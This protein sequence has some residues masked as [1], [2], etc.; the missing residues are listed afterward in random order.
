MFRQIGYVLCGGS[1]ATGYLGGSAAPLYQ[2]L[3]ESIPFPRPSIEQCVEH[4]CGNRK[5]IVVD[6]LTNQNGQRV[7]FFRY[8]NQMIPRQQPQRPRNP[9][10]RH[11]VNPQPIQH[12]QPVQGE[13][14]V[15]DNP[16][17]FAN[18]D[19]AMREGYRVEVTIGQGKVSEVSP[20]LIE[21]YQ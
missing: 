4:P 5:V 21:G 7:V 2:Y 17:D 3:P 19:K 8:P 12:Q 10:E 15:V 1:L 18:L 6:Q 11:Q 20:L 13:F 16:N 14:G 9:Y